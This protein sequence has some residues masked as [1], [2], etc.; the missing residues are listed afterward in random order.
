MIFPL[1][2]GYD[3]IV[4]SLE[5]KPMD[6]DED[7]SELLRVRTGLAR[8]LLEFSNDGKQDDHHFIQRD[9]ASALDTDWE[10]VHL[11]L[12]SMQLQGVI[13]FE[14]NRMIIDKGML[15]QIAVESGTT[16]TNGG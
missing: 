11:S 15:R 13:R 4:N 12:K 7:S 2:G 3:D 16:T 5:E 6:V 8:R 1:I 9:I 10:T 14:R